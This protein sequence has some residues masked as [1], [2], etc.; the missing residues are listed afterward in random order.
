MHVFVRA[1]VDLLDVTPTVD[2]PFTA[3]LIVMRSAT[4]KLPTRGR[5]SLFRLF[6]AELVI[7]LQYSQLDCPS[8]WNDMV[9]RLLRFFDIFSERISRNF[10]F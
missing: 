8:E 2:F 1:P 5:Q 10:K 3:Y 4:K 9:M 7:L 6:L